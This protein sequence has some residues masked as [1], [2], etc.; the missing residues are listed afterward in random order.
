VRQAL[1]RRSPAPSVL[2]PGAVAWKTG[3]SSGRRDAWCVGVTPNLVAVVWMG[4]LDG[5]AA[6]DLVG[7][8]AAAPLLA[9]VL[10]E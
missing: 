4:R 8:R 3:T 10:A 2:A 1:S 7:A 9:A 6:P 5:G